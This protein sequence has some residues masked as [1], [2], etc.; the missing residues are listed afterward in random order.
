[1]I[2]QSGSFIECFLLEEGTFG[3][4]SGERLNERKMKREIDV[5]NI[6]L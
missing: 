4:D 3:F 2:N 1:M 6:S 5:I